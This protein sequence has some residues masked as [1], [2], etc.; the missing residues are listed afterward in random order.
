MLTGQ[1]HFFNRYIDPEFH[2]PLQGVKNCRICKLLVN[3]VDT[4]GRCI[5][6]AISFVFQS[7][8]YS[9]FI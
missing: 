5:D 2:F 1:K 4:L 7:V 9:Q 6:Q 3:H 8:K